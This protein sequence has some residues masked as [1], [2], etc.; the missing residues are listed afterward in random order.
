MPKFKKGD[1]VRIRLDSSSINRGRVGII[2]EE[3]KQDTMGFWYIVKLEIRGFIGSYPFAEQ[4][5]E[6][7]NKP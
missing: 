3:P 2:D 5:L 6:S 1:K 7:V 4:D